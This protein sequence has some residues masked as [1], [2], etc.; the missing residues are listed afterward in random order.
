MFRR[1]FTLWETERA[2]ADTLP[3]NVPSQFSVSASPRLKPFSA[4]FWAGRSRMAREPRADAETAVAG[5]PHLDAVKC[6]VSVARSFEAERVEGAGVGC[7]FSKDSVPIGV[8]HRLAAGLAC[9]VPEDSV[10]G[11][12]PV[13][14][15]DQPVGARVPVVVAEGGTRLLATVPVARGMKL[16]CALPH[17][18]PDGA[19]PDQFVLG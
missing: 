2:P 5:Q 15:F 9:E 7:Y 14:S 19:G 17:P 6:V 1:R 18:I 4:R 12:F 10:L 11:R 16:A 3:E 13:L 8:D